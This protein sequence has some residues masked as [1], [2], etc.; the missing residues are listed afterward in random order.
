MQNCPQQFLSQAE[1]P[2]TIYI[3]HIGRECGELNKSPIIQREHIYKG[4]EYLWSKHL[5]QLHSL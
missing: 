2:S 3:F 5:A 4:S 1:E